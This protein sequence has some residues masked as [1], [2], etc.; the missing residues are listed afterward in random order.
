MERSRWFE[1]G[2]L[3]CVLDDACARLGLCVIE[4]SGNAIVV[5][6]LSRV[7]VVKMRIV[8]DGEMNRLV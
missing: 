3:E 2:E 1:D 7:L 4:W 6:M 5:S 8:V